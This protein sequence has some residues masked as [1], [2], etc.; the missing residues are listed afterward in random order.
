[1]NES[2]ATGTN[3]RATVALLLA[4][5]AAA[6]GYGVVLPVLPLLLESFLPS[7]SF[8][9]IGW[10]SGALTAIYAGAP[11]LSAPLWGRWSDRRG[12]RSLASSASVQLWL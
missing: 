7:A 11:L 2:G 5:F 1:M 12:R 6:V 10:H 9:S 4:V 8:S 3:R